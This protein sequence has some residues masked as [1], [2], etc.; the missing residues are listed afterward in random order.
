MVKTRY[1]EPLYAK[2][3]SDAVL[4]LARVMCNSGTLNGSAVSHFSFNSP[5][6]VEIDYEKGSQH[7]W[8]GYGKFRDEMEHLGFRSSRCQRMAP[9]GTDKAKLMFTIPD[10]LESAQLIHAAAA[11]KL[12]AHVERSL[13]EPLEHTRTLVGQVFPGKAGD[14][15]KQRILTEVA[16]NLGVA[17]LYIGRGS[18]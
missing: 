18:K 12:L 10:T 14:E 3:I 9:D 6:E 16:T 13:R 8:K 1:P 17:G 15:L 7:A 4:A 11:G 5:L 2:P